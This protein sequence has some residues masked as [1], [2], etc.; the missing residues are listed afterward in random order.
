MNPDSSASRKEFEAIYAQHYRAVWALAFARWMDSDSALDIMQE[1]FLRLW[2]QYEAKQEIKNPKAWL[3]RVA[4]NLA[5]DYSK[6]AFR[7]HGT[8]APDLLGT[9]PGMSQPPDEIL[10]REEAF[11]QIRG[12]LEELPPADREVLTMRYA[13]D[14]DA[15][16]IAE[17]LGVPVTA[18]HMRLSR[19]RQRL[20]EKLTAIGVTQSP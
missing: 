11:Q 4:R 18:I 7:R 19:A 17:F 5:E 9:L 13:L 3:M 10:Q 15:P 16:Q 20:A 14:Q 8:L 1:T 12:V 6:S 2:K